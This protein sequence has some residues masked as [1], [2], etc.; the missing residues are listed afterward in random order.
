MYR[1][2]TFI[3][4]LFSKNMNERRLVTS[5]DSSVEDYFEGLEK[6]NTKEK[7]SRTLRWSL[8]NSKK[9]F[10]FQ[11]NFTEKFHHPD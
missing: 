9:S 10:F 1:I 7:R 5:H 2:G 6:K 4:K 3:F 8:K 11:I